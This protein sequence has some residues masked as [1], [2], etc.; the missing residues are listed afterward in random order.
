VVQVTSPADVSAAVSSQFPF[1]YFLM[2]M[3]DSVC[4]KSGFGDCDQWWEA[5]HLG[6]CIIGRRVSN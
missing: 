4:Q 6:G 1:E 2:H 3:T 5:L